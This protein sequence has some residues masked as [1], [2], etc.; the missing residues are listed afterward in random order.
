MS[1]LRRAAMA[2]LLPP[3][4]A[5]LAAGCGKSNDNVLFD[6]SAGH[7]WNWVT[8]NGKASLEEQNSCPD[9]RG[10]AQRPSATRARSF[11]FTCV[12]SYASGL[13]AT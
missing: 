2:V 1:P 5:L 11:S 12:R 3:P 8:D 10:A 9:C 13:A 4:L 6:P 7:P